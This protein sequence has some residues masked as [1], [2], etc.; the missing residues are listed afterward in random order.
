M[1]R[2]ARQSAEWQHLVRWAKT[3][4][5][6]TCHLCGL[7]I[8]V[9]VGKDHPLAYALDHVISVNERPDLILSPGN[10]EPSHKLCN[11]R[12]K[13]RPLTPGLRLEMAERMTDREPIALKFFD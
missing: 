8:P 12:R 13:D 5:P 9:D 6:W 10:V 7:A 11:S 4:K 3:T 1:S 2:D